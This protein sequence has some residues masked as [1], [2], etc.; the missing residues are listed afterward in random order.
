LKKILRRRAFVAALL[1]AAGL[2]AGIASPAAAAGQEPATSMI[3]GGQDAKPGAYPWVASIQQP[4][5]GSGQVVSW[6]GGALVEP[7]DKVVTASHCAEHFTAGYT[8]VRVGA[9]NWAEGGQTATVAAIF[10]HPGYLPGGDEPGNDIAV[11]H[12]DHKLSGP[13]IKIGST[14]G[15]VG[16]DLRVIGYG[17]TC[18]YGSPEWPCYPAGLQ[19]AN[20]TLVNDDLCSYYDRSV[21]LCTHGN[22]GQM[23]C[24]GDSGGP[25]LRKVAGKHGRQEWVLVGVVRGDGDRD[26]SDMKC[27]QGLG[28]FTDATKY[29][30]WV[31]RTGNGPVTP[32]AA[33][34]PV[35]AS[36]G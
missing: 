6:C 16:S 28:V 29:A 5:P 21:E 24:F 31:A 4:L 18:D 19:E 8:T 22:N 34:V 32:P 35:V 11:L 7:G 27:S 14:P 15:R 3:V 12:L 9:Y 10:L 1:A 33:R 20:L 23:A 26:Q 2:A 17:A 36:T 30:D 13:T 25:L